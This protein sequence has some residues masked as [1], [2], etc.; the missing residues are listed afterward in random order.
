MRK[1]SFRTS[2]YRADIGSA[3]DGG[4]QQ[5]GVFILNLLLLGFCILAIIF[6]NGFTS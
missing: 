5:I 4:C 6:L 2:Y 3:A 1:Q